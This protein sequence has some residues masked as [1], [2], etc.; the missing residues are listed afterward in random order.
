VT[1]AA[2]VKI[3]PCDLKRA[4][5]R[6]HDEGD[7][8]KRLVVLAAA[9]STGV[10]GLGAAPLVAQAS[11]AKAPAVS[12][13]ACSNETI[14]FYESIFGV[15]A[16]CGSLKV[17][18]DYRHPRGKKITLALSR[19][20]HTGTAAQ[21]KG[22]LVV[23]PGGP[24]GTGI[25]FGVRV[26]GQSSAALKAAYDFIGFDPRGVG[27]SVPALTC[28]NDYF[29]PVR[30]DYVPGSKAEE[31]A[32]VKKSKAYA[33]AC[34][35]KWGWMLG[36]MK[37]TDAVHDMDAI[38]VALGQK[39]FNYYGA[40]Y[41]TALGS[42]YATLFPTKVGRM[43]LDSN[44]RPSGEW[45]GD[46]IDQ[47]YAFD[48]NA[49]L[50]FA[51]VAK[52]DSTYHVGTTTDAVRTFYY[53]TRA[54]LAK[55]PAQGIV[56]PDEFDDSFLVAGYRQSQ[57]IWGEL[58]SVLSAFKAGDDD[59]LVGAFHDF[60]E[61]T[62]DNGFAVYSAVECTDAAWPKNWAKWHHD[63]VKVYAKAPFLTWGNTWYN[64]PCAFWPAAP[65]KPV[66]VRSTKGLPGILLFQAT[67]DAA[68][69]F[70]GG[71]EMHKRFKG[72]SLVIEDGGKTHG[73]VHRGNAPID[74][75]FDAYLL[76][77]TLPPS[78]V[79]VPALPDP[80]PPAPA[81]AARALAHTGKQSVQTD[82]IG[83]P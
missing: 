37:T 7:Y 14:A 34:G 6:V 40:S 80:V 13:G 77:G 11:T 62:D 75:Y 8:V 20:R 21:Y 60:A 16:E 57:A 10:A 25:D 81:A 12:W 2:G 43:V 44:V 66:N 19:V 67:L 41:G 48:R 78:T 5:R 59:P 27:S 29:K 4:Q 55:A 68:T 38:R 53:D 45:Y 30:P 63:S 15:T 49:Q 35:Q 1:K 31:A 28:D 64:A 54:K 18:L 26:A 9:A 52:Y 71:L 47:N 24:G 73:V 79:H 23:N 61:T 46:N 58:A 17:P 70:P 83:R 39:K 36:H 76:N 82:I 51:W 22:A 50:F 56:G 33:K 69:P 74:A 32:W 72:S 42:V 65:G 3:S